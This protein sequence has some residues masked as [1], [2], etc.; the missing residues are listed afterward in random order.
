MNQKNKS[1]NRNNPKMTQMAKLLDSDIEY[2]YKYTESYY[3]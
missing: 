2:Y 1:I 3:I